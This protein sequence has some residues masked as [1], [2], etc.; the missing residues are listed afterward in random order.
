MKDITKTIRG[1]LDILETKLTEFLE[2]GDNFQDKISAHL[3]KA[4]GKRVR[5]ALF[6]TTAKALGLTSENRFA[7]AAAL[8]YIH[9][10]SLLHDDVI[11]SANTR[12]GKPTVNALWDNTVAVLSG[13]RIHATASRLLICARSFELFDKVCEAVQ[14]MSE[15]EIFQLTILWKAGTTHEEYYRVVLGK[16]AK[17]FEVSALAAA[18]ILN[19]PT[20]AVN[21]FGAYGSH[22][23]F[24][25]QIIDDCLDFE[26]TEKELGKPVMLDLIEGKITLPLILAMHHE[27]EHTIELKNLIRT[28][29]D[30]K[31]A[32]P[33]QIER[34]HWLVKTTNGVQKAR[35][36]AKREVSSAIENLEHAFAHT[37][38]AHLDSANALRKVPN[39]LL[40]RNA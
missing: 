38:I 18:Q 36:I 7:V 29:C 37:T 9:T 21:H 31:H 27:G 34:V 19:L 17:L 10:A 5:P 35:E 32:T 28:I 2:T 39:L 6:L 13:D 25:F 16:T 11:D 30:A 12:R 14:K 40:E 22:M 33:E 23:G 8:E 15:G 3:F 24:A 26:G 4:G 1:D 20:N